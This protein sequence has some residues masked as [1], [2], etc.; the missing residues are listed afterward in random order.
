MN[1]GDHDD[2]DALSGDRYLATDTRRPL[3][4]ANPGRLSTQVR[5]DV[6]DDQPSLNL[7]KYWDML[8]KHR[9]LIAGVVAGM[10]A[11]GLVWTLLTTPIY[12]AS[13][14]VQIEREA[15]KVI[16][17]QGVE[18]EGAVD[19][20]FYQ[21]QYALLKSRS[22]AERVVDRLNLTQNEQFMNQR[23]TSPLGSLRQMLRGSPSKAQQAADR[24]AQRRRAVGILTSSLTIAP[25]PASHLV[26]IHYESPNPR[27]AAQVSNAVAENFIGAN[28]DR[29]FEASSYA[30]KFL[31]ERLAQVKARLE[32]S[33]QQLVAYAANQN[34][35]DIQTT[36]S[37]GTQSSQSL[38]ASNLLA[39]NAALSAASNERIRAEQRW[40]QAQS[41][42]LNIT[43]VLESPTIQTLRQ[44]RAT[45]QVQYQ[46][47]LSIFKPEHPTMVQLKS[48]MAEL[49]R[50]IAAEVSTVKGGIRSQYEIAARQEAQLRQ[51]VAG[52]TSGVLDL[53]NRSIQYNILQ[54]E[55][56]T[57]RTLYDGLLQ[58][59]KEIGVAGGVG[60]NNVSIV[61]KAEPPGRPYK[62]NL[63]M[64][65]LTAAGLGLLL[66][67]GAAFVLETLDETIKVPEDIEGKIGIPLLGAIPVLD[68]GITPEEALADPRSP[69]SEAYYSVRTA[70]QFST[71]DGVPRNLLITS[72]RPSE[73]KST[74][75]V[76]LAHNF[77][78]LG[79]KVLLVDADLR[80]P[81]LHRAMRSDN[82]AGLANY[83]T[84]R[85]PL[86]DLVQAT[87]QPNLVFMPCGPLPPNPAELL[88]GGRVR[89]LMTD[90]AEAFDLLIIDGPPVL[91]LADAPLLASVVKGTVLV[92]EAGTTRQRV[93]K[94]ALRRLDVGRAH[95]L[96][97]LLSKFSVKT[98]GYG[99]GSGYNYAYSY[100][101]GV[102]NIEAKT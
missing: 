41:S 10:L 12:R 37:D 29:R 33:E 102:K 18:P 75:A 5:Y 55:V 52:L 19:R 17:V 60:T 28:L 35:L 93:V 48:Q 91:G 101:Y 13:T 80:N 73:G 72:A 86:L 43:E 97:A 44:Q 61:D 82:S 11:L 39:M 90:A 15:A 3:V 25:V 6:D 20:E 78:K 14:V 89:D 42:G 21:T 23:G 36:T 9:W 87:D 99:Y 67:I 16:D 92:V 2:W 45:L 83:L 58:R 79:M 57:N 31:E 7:L 64:N 53:R 69:F 65:L 22:L 76:A 88:A 40:R 71:T 30:R 84:G 24:N 26:G 1:R 63:L 50:Q 85:V 56:D 59:Y 34:I 62:P 8:L 49:D 98:A 27:L 46:E 77:A 68:K 70:L 95:V 47:K 81:S 96:G 32:Q 94:A 66:G 74:S 51:Q 4:V 38:P 100:D 54:R